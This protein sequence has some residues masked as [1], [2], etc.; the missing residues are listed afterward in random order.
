MSLL[1][2]IISAFVIVPAIVFLMG[3]GDHKNGHVIEIAATT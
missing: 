3:R 2:K 1:Y